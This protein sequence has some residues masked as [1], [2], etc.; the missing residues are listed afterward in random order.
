VTK[1]ALLLSGIGAVIAGYHHYLQL[2]GES[3]VPCS[4]S[5]FAV[6][7]TERYVWEFGYIGIPTISLTAFLLIMVLLRARQMYL[8]TRSQ[9]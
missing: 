4:A 7:C 6:S 9:G 8:A 2:G 1:Y 3:L 5:I